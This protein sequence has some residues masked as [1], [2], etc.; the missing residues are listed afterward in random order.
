MD[1][2]AKAAKI[3]KVL[4]VKYMLYG[5]IAKFGTENDYKGVNAGAF[6][7]NKFGL[8]TIG[9]KSGKAVVAFTLKAT[10]TTIIGEATEA[11]V[12]DGVT[13]LVAMKDR[14]IGG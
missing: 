2:G 6:G 12:K 11:A 10:D 5:T 13:K 3:G 14:I 8:G 7:G 9:T 1:P 4:G